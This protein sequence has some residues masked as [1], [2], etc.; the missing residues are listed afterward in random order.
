MKNSKEVNSTGKLLDLIKTGEQK[1]TMEYV[2]DDSHTSVDSNAS[3]P[4]STKPK[5]STVGVWI[6]PRDITLVMTSNKGFVKKKGLVKWQTI[7]LPK[8]LLPENI[9]PENHEFPAFLKDCLDNFLEG[10]KNIPIWCALESSSLKIRNI[11]IPDI[12][13]AKIANAAFWGLKK[14]M[15]FNEDQEIFNFEVHGDI[16]IDGIKKKNILVFSAPRN[17]IHS[18]EKTFQEAGYFLTGITS[19]PFAVQNFVRT[20]Q[21]Q[22]D[23]PYFAF[24]NISRETTETY[25]FSLS[26]ILLVRTLRTGSQHLIEELD[27][28]L[29]MDSIDHLSSMS[30]TDADGFS[31]FRDISDRLISKI[32]RTGDYCAQHYTGNTPMDRYIFYG[33]MDL[34]M[35]FMNQASTMIPAEVN[36]FEPVRDTLSGSLETELPLDAKQRNCVLT[37]FGIAC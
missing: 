11:L 29:G 2:S 5:N 17:E 30:E 13:Q 27:T 9:L 32:V 25:C 24:V 4:I 21:I 37:A 1:Q 6:T 7:R 10:K 8:I 35:P 16:N 34:C 3:L 36:I 19:I 31:Q 22:M 20:G 14:E 12:P 33:E 28:P 18:W 15:E 23:D 26:G